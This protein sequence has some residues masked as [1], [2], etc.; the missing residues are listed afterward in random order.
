MEPLQNVE[1]ILGSN[2]LLL[3]RAESLGL[4]IPS[5]VLPAMFLRNH[6]FRDHLPIR[7]LFDPGKTSLHHE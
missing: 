1:Q 6:S 7:R 2:R 5:Q 4:G 3:G